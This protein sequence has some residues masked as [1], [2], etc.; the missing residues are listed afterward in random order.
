MSS[1]PQISAQDCL[2]NILSY[3]ENTYVSDNDDDDDDTCSTCSSYIVIWVILLFGLTVSPF[4]IVN[5]F[6]WKRLTIC[7]EKLGGM[8]IG[9]SEPR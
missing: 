4:R 6:I 2:R 9:N 7:V 8:A 1:S 5:L 3:P